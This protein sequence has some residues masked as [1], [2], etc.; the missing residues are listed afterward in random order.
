MRRNLSF[1]GVF[2]L[3]F[4]LF[5]ALCAIWKIIPTLDERGF[6]S[7]EL[8]TAAVVRYHPVMDSQFERKT[9]MQIKMD[10]SFL[11]V[12][13]GEQHP[14]MYDISLKGWA[15]LFGDS[16]TSLRGFNI[17]IIALVSV[18][19]FVSYWRRNIYPI[20]ILI[21]FTTLV[22]L[23]HPVTQSY[24]TQ[25]RS[26]I[27][28]LMLSLLCL[29]AFYKIKSADS[30]E[31]IWRYIFYILATISFLTHYYMAV[32]IGAVYIFIA[33]GDLR[34]RRYIL[35]L[36]PAPFIL[37]WIFLS[38]HSLLFTASGGVAWSQISYVQA[39]QSM[40][41]IIYGYFGLSSIFIL[42]SAIYFFF[43][44]RSAEIQVVISI[45]V[46]ICVL[47]FVCKKSGILHPRH[48]IF[49]IPWCIYLIINATLS[50]SN[51]KLSLLV[52]SSFIV[53]FA[54]S[55][56]SQANIYAN[57][58]YKEAAKYISENY[59]KKGYKIY[60]TWSPNE[61]YYRYYL[62]NYASDNVNID[63]LSNIN[64]VNK[65]CSYIYDNNVV[66]YAHHS[67]NDVINAFESCLH[68]YKRIDFYGIVVIAKP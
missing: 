48:F 55:A 11:T 46:A 12:K 64:D 38:Y 66:L 51:N 14:P 49:I 24:A 47:A 43:K 19:I 18:T 40:L 61:A 10:D 29:W 39:L 16:E 21:V 4:Y 15:Y 35:P 41:H 53:F 54:P 33:Y 57:E 44:R 67:H 58:Q 22:V 27:F 34:A 60:A 13:A 8:F 42:F 31:T 28:F 45:V 37:S 7:D 56:D 2:E 68:I 26:Y 30:H 20:G 1:G 63:M 25:A 32:F 3:S 9:V 5:I 36:I 65:V 52:V 59:S 6:W 17:F 50:L 23:W 62:E